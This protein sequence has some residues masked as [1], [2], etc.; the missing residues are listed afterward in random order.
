MDARIVRPKR[1]DHVAGRAKLCEFITAKKVIRR[2]SLLAALTHALHCGAERV[3]WV[4]LC[5]QTFVA[6]RPLGK[7]WLQCVYSEFEGVWITDRKWVPAQKIPADDLDGVTLLIEEEL[8]IR[9]A[10]AEEA[11]RVLASRPGP[12][13]QA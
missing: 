4:S 9:R 6:Y 10:V 8:A 2:R 13:V 1:R 12:K 3:E 11:A 5:T 7:C